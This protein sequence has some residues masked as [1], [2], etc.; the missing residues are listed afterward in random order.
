MT[1]KF[2]RRRL[3]MTLVETVIYAAILAVVAIAVV[4]ML[5]AGLRTFANFRLARNI[6]QSAEVALER[7]G[8]EIRRAESVDLTQSSL[9]VHP[10]RLA[11]TFPIEA[12]SE[13][14]EFYLSGPTLPVLVLVRGG[15]EIA[16]TAEGITVE[17]LIFRPANTS[18]SEGVKIELRLAA[19]AG[20][21]RRAENFYLTAGLRGSY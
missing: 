14:A 2:S 16:L 19:A 15:A 9:G 8:R 21:L 3:G 20:S 1:M 12:G 13:T 17:N 5:L 6:S 11:L 4:S 10:G 18:L 7:L